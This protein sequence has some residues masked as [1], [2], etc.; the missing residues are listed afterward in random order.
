M[1]IKYMYSVAWLGDITET[2]IS[3]VYLHTAASMLWLI[4]KQYQTQSKQSILLLS[5]CIM[6]HVQ[7]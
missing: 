5:F 4:N 3:L 1:T 2:L 6:T 7:V